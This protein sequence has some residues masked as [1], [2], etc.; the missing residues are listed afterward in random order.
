M[1]DKDD[2]LHLFAKIWDGLS[3][4]QR[5]LVGISL[6][7]SWAAVFWVGFWAG[8]LSADNRVESVKAIYERQ[9]TKLENQVVELKNHTHEVRLEY[10]D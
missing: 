7:T 10:L 2:K 8:N 6:G 3:T 1:S 9:I 5:F 4:S